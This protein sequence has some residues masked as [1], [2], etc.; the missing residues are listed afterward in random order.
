M[1]VLYLVSGIGPPAGWGTEF[2][3]NLIF[4]L[5][6]KG[7]QATII[8]PIYKHT[9]PGWRKW[10]K[11]M[12]EKYS[13]R[14]ISL[15][16]PAWIK[17]RLLVHFALTPLLVTKAA[18]KLLRKERFNLV[19]EFSSTPV[20]LFRA[21]LC[22]LFFK[23]P[24]IF[25]LS[26]SNNTFLGK[27]FWFKLFNFAKTYCI[28]SKE[29]INSLKD[30]G[31]NSNKIFF[32]PPGIEINKFN[33]TLNK[34]VARTKLNLPKNK[35]ILSFFGS[36]TEEKGIPDL[37]NAVQKIDKSIK[38]NLLVA[39]FAV[40]KGS[41]NHKKWVKKLNELSPYLKVFEKH[42]N[43]PLVIA[44]SDMVILPQRTGHGATIPPI[45]VLEVLS[46]KTILLTTNIIGNREIV[47]PPDV[48]LP[49]NDPESLSRAIEKVLHENGKVH[50]RSINLKPYDLAQATA[51][52]LK[53]Y[54]SFLQS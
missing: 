52:Y 43:V 54:Q 40:W 50:K 4:K 1:K 11:E 17:E 16:A 10:T 41:T 34:S 15:E 47:K 6:Q 14:V 22:R 25:T 49:P 45:S 23:T 26:V 28:P 36:L 7:V 18:I 5:S 2:I 33:R 24:T 44:A 9:H 38:N 3:Q 48:L 31:V 29:I 30:I 46:S 19:H 42:A 37:L 21:L 8:N 12:E 39:V 32:S 27:L 20:I 51:N 13:V 53:I 35:I